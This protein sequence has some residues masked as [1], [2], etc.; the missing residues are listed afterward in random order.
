MTF[1]VIC[2]LPCERQINKFVANLQQA[3]EERFENATIIALR[4][5]YLLGI[6]RLSMNLNV[7]RFILKSSW[8]IMYQNPP[9]GNFVMRIIRR[10][11][12]KLKN[13]GPCEA[14]KV[15]ELPK[16]PLGRP[17]MLSDIDQDVQKYIKQMRLCGDVINT[18]VVTAA[19]TGFMLERNKSALAD[20]GG[21]IKITTSYAKSL[22]SRMNFVKRKGSS[23]AKITPA[24]FE[25]VK[26]P[27]WMK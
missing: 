16:K 18:T 10:Y 17:L 9:V 22:L 6:I 1:Q 11:R 27:S 19:A 3:S 8:D 26:K 23:A 13:L 14:I 12:N 2:H 21:S 25:V 15:T 24:E 5:V 20:Y 7:P 4:C